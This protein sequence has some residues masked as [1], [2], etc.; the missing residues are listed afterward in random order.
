MLELEK[1]QSNYHNETKNEGMR[2]Q[3]KVDNWGQ[4]ASQFGFKFNI[5]T[6][7][8]EKKKLP[9]QL[10]VSN[11]DLTICRAQTHSNSNLGYE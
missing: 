4:N 5:S 6:K 9:K 10:Q 8:L 7:K 2:K 1:K 11:G 3:A